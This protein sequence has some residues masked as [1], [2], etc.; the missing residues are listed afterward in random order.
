MSEAKRL[1]YFHRFCSLLVHI[2]CLVSIL[3]KISSFLF[4]KRKKFIGLEPFEG[5]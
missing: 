3:F 1:I 5:K 2:N 4:R